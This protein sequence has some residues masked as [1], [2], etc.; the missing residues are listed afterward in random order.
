MNQLEHK[1][2]SGPWEAKAKNRP[3]EASAWMFQREGCDDEIR[4]RN[5]YLAIHDRRIHAVSACGSNNDP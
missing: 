2:K 3:Q 1:T 5:V 4:K